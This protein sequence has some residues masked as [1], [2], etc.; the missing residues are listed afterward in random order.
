MR[1]D[2]ERVMPI[3][4]PN[5]TVMNMIY[6]QLVRLG[7]SSYFLTQSRHHLQ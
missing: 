6:S 1:F 5:L 4:I 7:Q 2:V 3:E